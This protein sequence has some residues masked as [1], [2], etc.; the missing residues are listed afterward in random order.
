MSTSV[1]AASDPLIGEELGPKQLVASA[2]P[3][4]SYVNSTGDEGF[5]R[6]AAAM[7]LAT[8]SVKIQ[9]KS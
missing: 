6:H 1:T 7:R 4:R 3:I 9:T 2:D 5:A 8:A